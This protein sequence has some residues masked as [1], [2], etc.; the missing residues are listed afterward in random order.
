M[1]S[2]L[3]LFFCTFF[4][5]F[6]SRQSVMAENHYR[7]VKAV[8]G[9]VVG[10]GGFFVRR[11]FSKEL[12]KLEKMQNIFVKL[13]KVDDANDLRIKK[14]TRYKYFS[15]YASL[16]GFGYVVK[17][18]AGRLKEI[19]EKKALEERESEKIEEPILRGVEESVGENEEA[20]TDAAEIYELV[21]E[22]FDLIPADAVFHCDNISIFKHRIGS[23]L[24]Y[25]IAASRSLSDERS[26]PIFCASKQVPN[27][28]WQHAYDA[29]DVAVRL[30][31]RE[32]NGKK[33]ANIM[34]KLFRGE[35]KNHLNSPEVV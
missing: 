9:I 22:D 35:F 2:F 32:W 16:L 31:E 7:G 19:A 26:V 28:K 30:L 3:F 34:W 21:E 10:V 18:V 24:F 14:L 8:A 1:R 29:Y 20:V 23:V 5:F 33:S 6:F 11:Y 4:F 13:G 27:D 15:L 25:G 12:E 17:Q